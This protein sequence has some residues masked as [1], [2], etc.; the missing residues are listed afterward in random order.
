[1][2]THPMEGH[3]EFLG[4]GGG[5]LKAKLLEEPYENNLAFPRERGMQNK[6]TSHVGSMDIFWN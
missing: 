1:M 6:K 4:G 3:G 5:G 2:H